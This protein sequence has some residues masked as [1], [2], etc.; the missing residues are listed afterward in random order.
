V[1]ND[2]KDEIKNSENNNNKSSNDSKGEMN[3]SDEQKILT[4]IRLMRI[5]HKIIFQQLLPLRLRFGNT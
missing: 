3:K 4:K 2:N 1:V 5:K